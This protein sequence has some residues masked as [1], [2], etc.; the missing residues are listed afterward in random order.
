MVTKIGLALGSGAARGWSQIGVFDG[1]AA[2]GIVPEVVCGTSIGAL[3]GAAFVT[4]KL[5]TLKDRMERLAAVMLRPCSTF[6]FPPV[7]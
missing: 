4:G 7:A 6:V 3:V 2:L 1:L 5:S